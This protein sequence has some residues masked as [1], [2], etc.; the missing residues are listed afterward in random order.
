MI[1]FKTLKWKNFLS[2]GN[3]YTEIELDRNPSTLVIGD[4]GAGKSTFLDALSFALYGK[5]FRKVS[6]GQL[7]NSIN[8]KDMRVEL[9][10]KK[11]KHTYKIIRGSKPNIFE[12]WQN[13]KMMNQD[14][15]A[16]DYQEHL[17]KHILKLTHKAFSQV[18]VLGST[19]FIPFM[20][21]NSM[22][23][24]EVIED[25]LDL[26]IFSVMKTLL[27]EKVNANA[28]ELSDIEH[29]LHLL[30]EK[31]NLTQEHLNQLEADNKERIANNLS[32][33]T[34]NNA[35]I[36]ALQGTISVSNDDLDSLGKAIDDN[37]TV[38]SRYEKLKELR[39]KLNGKIL[40]LQTQLDFYESNE[41]C[42]VCHQDIDSE[43]K[44]QTVCNHNEKIVELND[45]IEK[46]QDELNQAEKR[47]EEIA[48]IQQKI[49]TVQND[50]QQNQFAVN[51]LSD[52]NNKLLEENNSL[53]DSKGSRLKEQKRLDKFTNDLETTN[54]SKV[55]AVND[56]NTLSVASTIL[57]DTGIKSKII[58]QYVPI[59]NK[60]INKY[61]AAMDFF[62]QFEL[63]ENFTETIR[64]RF[65][66]D[67]SYASFSEGE[68]MRIDLA[69]LFTWR[70]IS[71]IR[72]SASTNLLIMDEVFDSSLDSAGTD[73][74]LK[75][76]RELTSDTNVYII[77][78]KGDTLIDKFH[79]VIKFEKVKSF[80]RMAS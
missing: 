19:S 23:R 29:N 28:K 43:F 34:K 39:I 62:V 9:V 30:E 50:I 56:K 8:K 25:L 31:I 58:K 20:Q 71:K 73:E 49:I 14:A 65:R 51:T 48:E 18:V 45:G 26:Q 76:L 11:G 69:L 27:K 77:S 16:R 24:R 22:N 79:N 7:I 10:F 44:E 33:V 60:L 52:A 75:I 66:D 61:L 32:I 15:N 35:E 57:M 21:L 4:N 6:K 5:P 38:K 55:V 42:P 68:K 70:S 72:N 37:K 40:D 54:R 53:N 12:I 67:F 47:L 78:H 41:E 64:S 1:K 3:A 80:S 63:D 2:T 74:F 59:M 46:L 36:K 13:G 17:E